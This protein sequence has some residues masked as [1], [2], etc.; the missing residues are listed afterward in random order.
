MRQTLV[1]GNCWKVKLALLSPLVLLLLT[2]K[3]SQDQTDIVQE[4]NASPNDS[5]KKEM[6]KK[7]LSPPIDTSKIKFE[8]W[9]LVTR[10]R[11]RTKA[12]DGASVHGSQTTIVHMTHGRI[13]K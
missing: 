12:G 1:A 4:V 7:L 3:G 5:A 6:N 13:R 8:P 9:M 10:W 11:G 2:S